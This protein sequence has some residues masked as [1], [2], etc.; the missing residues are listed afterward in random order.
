VIYFFPCLF[1]FN[2]SVRLRRALKTDDQIKLNQSLKNQKML[3]RYM[4]IVT[5]I[6]LAIYAI[7]LLIGGLTMLFARG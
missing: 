5:I 6:M 4:G 2:Y 7:L 3:Y 1:L